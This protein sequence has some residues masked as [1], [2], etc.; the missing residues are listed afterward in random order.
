[1]GCGL[2]E[3]RRLRSSPSTTRAGR[4]PAQ[5]P[6][7]VSKPGWP[8]S[9]W[10]RVAT[11]KPVFSTIISRAPA[12]LA[13][14]G[15]TLNL[16]PVTD[17]NVEPAQSDHRR[18]GAQSSRRIRVWSQRP[19]GSSSGRIAPP[20]WQPASNTS[21]GHGSTSADS[22]LGLPDITQ[23]WSEAE[24]DPFAQ[25]VS[26]GL[27]DSVMMAHLFHASMSDG[28]V[29]PTSLSKRAVQMLRRDIGFDGPIS[30]DDLQMGAVRNAYCRGRLGARSHGGR[31]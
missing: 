5:T 4:R 27:A 20:G 16:A 8:R 7:A 12:Q 3:A 24:L 22:H 1:M 15:I 17:L 21:P 10:W 19:R 6:R 28:R 23:S 26:E 11:L 9:R 31:Q 25:L 30:T 29:Q 2:R 13:K 14:A 18:V